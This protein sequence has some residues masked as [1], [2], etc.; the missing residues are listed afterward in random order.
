MK[1]VTGGVKDEDEAA[2]IVTSLTKR[3]TRT[4]NTPT[5]LSMMVVIRT[6]R[7]SHNQVR[8]FVILRLIRFF[9]V[10]QP[11]ILAT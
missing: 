6:L 8:K 10:Y 4:R 5:N 11:S 3:F 2:S 9:L 1:K 7:L